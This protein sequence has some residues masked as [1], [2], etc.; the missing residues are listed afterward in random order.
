MAPAQRFQQ[1]R[2]PKAPAAEMQDTNLETRLS[3]RQQAAHHD[4]SV[5][6]GDNAKGGGT[7]SIDAPE[8]KKDTDQSKEGSFGGDQGAS[9]K[10]DLD[11][12]LVKRR[13]EDDAV[14][15]ERERRPLYCEWKKASDKNRKY[16]PRTREVSLTRG[17]CSGEWKNTAC[18]RR[19]YAHGCPAL[20]QN[21]N[22]GT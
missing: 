18:W 4:A 6:D 2:N 21:A 9:T 15:T 5:Q 16:V 1:G 7:T 10:M 13:R 3:L 12:A 14:D 22:G 17:S 20:I 19:R 8:Q 11:P